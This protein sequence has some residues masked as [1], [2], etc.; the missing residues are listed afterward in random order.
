MNANRRTRVDVGLFPRRGPLPPSP[1]RRPLG[2]EI[3][4]FGVTRAA[5][6]AAEKRADDAQRPAWRRT[7]GLKGGATNRLP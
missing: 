6:S 4:P 2:A 5:R 1:R 7:E 3:L